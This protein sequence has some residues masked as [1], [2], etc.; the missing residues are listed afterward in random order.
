MWCKNFGSS[1]FGSCHNARVDGR[2]DRQTD[3]F[4]QQDRAYM[5]SQS[6]GTDVRRDA[7]MMS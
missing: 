1:L 5:H 7:V 3:R 4:R 6:H 2:T